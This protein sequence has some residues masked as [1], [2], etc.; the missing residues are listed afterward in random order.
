[1][2]KKILAKLMDKEWLLR[3]ISVSYGASIAL[4]FV[5]G[6]APWVGYA[7]IAVWA[8]LLGC[9]IRLNIKTEKR[10]SFVTVFYILLAVLLTVYLIY[11]AARQ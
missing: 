2:K 1:M 7:A 6:P 11:I 9:L 10:L 3:A 5:L 4:R 8:L